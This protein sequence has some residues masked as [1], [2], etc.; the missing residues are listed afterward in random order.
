[1][2]ETK[3]RVALGVYGDPKIVGGQVSKGAAALWNFGVI[4]GLGGHEKEGRKRRT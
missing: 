4:G 1:L 2:K 3:S